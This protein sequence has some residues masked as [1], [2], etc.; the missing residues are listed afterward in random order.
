[1][2][3][4]VT[5]QKI[6]HSDSLEFDFGGTGNRGKLYFNASDKEETKKRIDAF[7]E[8]RKYAEEK[9]TEMKE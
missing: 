7:V 8:A 4:N 3:E 2:T 5:I 9:M 1:M 6:E